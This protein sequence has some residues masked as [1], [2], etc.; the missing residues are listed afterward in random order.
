MSEEEFMRRAIALAKLGEGHTNPNPLVGAVIVKN[1]KI[2][3]EGYHE[4]YGSLHAERNA[5][6]NCTESPEDATIYVTLEPC[7]HFGKQPPC[8]MAIIDAGIKKVVIGS[9]DPN[10]LVSGKGAAQLREAGIE[11]VQDFLR[12]EC[13]AL[14][15]VFF[16]YME[17]KR[18]YVALKYAMSADGKITDKDGA[19]QW[20]TGEEARKHVHSLRNKYAGILAGIGTVLADDPMLNVRGIENPAQPTR[21]IL[22]TCGRIPLDSKLVKTAKEIPLIIACCMMEVSKKEKLMEAGAKIIMLPRPKGTQPKG[23]DP[24]GQKFEPKGSV[25][26]GCSV[27]I[28]DLMEA[29]YEEKIDSILVEGGGAVNGSFLST[30]IFDKVYTYVGGKMLGGCGKSPVGGAGIAL[31]DAALLTPRQVQTFG[32]DLLIEYDVKRSNTCLQG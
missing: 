26:F 29:L 3:G 5:L 22:D 15:D 27:P 6:K 11:V 17:K 20:I 19:S 18:P 32:N 4:V 13:D 25:P 8:T 23:T 16:C 31:P 12:E 24:F 30:G 9:R 1:G 21:I 7:C 10:P 2:I 14:N 28:G